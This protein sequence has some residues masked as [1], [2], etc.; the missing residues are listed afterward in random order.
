MEQLISVVKSDNHLSANSHP[1]LP[2]YRQLGR[3]DLTVSCL[4]IG[5]GGGISSEDTIYAFEQGINYFFYSSDLHHYTYINMADALRQLCGR[6]SSVRE[7]VVLATVTYIKSPE[8]LFGILID[9]FEELGI[10]YIDVL[11]WGWVG[12]RDAV[13]IQD[14]L[15]HSPHL[16]GPNTVYQRFV[17]ETYGVSERLKKMGAVR[18]I[19]ASF[20]NLNLAQAWLNHPFLDVMMVRHNPAHR[21]A[22]K[23][24]FAN[25]D[26]E[27]PQRSGIVTFKSIGEHIMPHPTLPEWCW[28]PDVPD[29]Y[30]YSLSQNCVD[31]AL[32]GVTN[33]EEIDQAIAAIQKGKLSPKEI[34]YLNLY[35]DMVRYD[36]NIK[37]LPPREL[38]RLIRQAK[39]E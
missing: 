28:R 36:I 26:A 25:L 7:K 34:D 33:R 31:I 10:D 32:T 12:D 39:N 8:S 15:E 23:K 3:T 14:C 37:N 16:R 21:A 29:F 11:F 35:A 13:V 27:D 22:Q 19:G 6:G 18:Y 30:R 1:S 38:F 2:F 17:E 24:I 4:G 9:Q 20:H 5:G